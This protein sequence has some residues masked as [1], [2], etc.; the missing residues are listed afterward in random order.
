[1]SVLAEIIV[2]VREDLAV[3]VAQT[4]LSVVQDHARAAAPAIAV[5]PRLMVDG[6]QLIAEVKRSSPSKGALAQIADPASLARDYAEAGAAAISV[7]TEHRRF[8]GSLADLA[9]VRA[10]VSIPLLRKDFMVEE[11]QFWEARAYGADIVLLIVAAL[12]QA[13]LKSFMELARSLGMTALVEVH[14][15]AETERALQAGADVIGINARNLKT[16]EV[17]R[18]VFARLAPLIPDNCVRIAE[19][20]VRTALDVVEYGVAG[21]DVVLVGEALVTGSDPRASA[22]AMIQAGQAVGLSS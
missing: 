9:A 1:M 4:P 2:G 14:D 13:M 17:D 12:D 21:A 20:G 10:A 18:A 3:R 11:Y 22:R 7:L 15:E 16:L 8:N 6:V 5:I 19:S